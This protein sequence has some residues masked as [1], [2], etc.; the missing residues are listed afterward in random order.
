M[1]RVSYSQYVGR[2]TRGEVVISRKREGVLCWLEILRN[3][4]AITGRC[5]SPHDSTHPQVNAHHEHPWSRDPDP[6]FH[7]WAGQ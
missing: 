7:A 4:C 2:T 3:V 6:Q 5:Q 1:R